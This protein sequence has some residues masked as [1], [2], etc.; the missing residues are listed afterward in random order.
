[1]DEEIKP[2]LSSEEPA[3]ASAGKL[4]N[5]GEAKIG[6]RRISAVCSRQPIVLRGRLQT[7]TPKLGALAL[8]CALFC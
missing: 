3:A 7:E 8:T 1:M 2:N 5:N 6:K 4:L